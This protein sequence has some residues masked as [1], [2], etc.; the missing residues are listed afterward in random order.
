MDILKHNSIAWDNEVKNKNK[1]TIPVT[2]EEVE[3]AKNGEYTLLLTPTKAV[4]REWTSDLIGK[5]VLCL[6]SGG[7]Q[8]GPIFAALGANVTVFDN[9]KEQLLKDKM[10]SERDNLNIH[11]EK[12]DMRD[13][14]RFEDETFDFIFHP[15]SN[16]FI[17]DI[18]VVW[19][20][21]YRVLKKGGILISGF[22]NPLIYIFDLY[23]W[24]QNSKLVI[25]N[26]IPYSDIEQLPKDQ[27]K[28]R[29][30]TNDTLEFGHSLQS[31]IGDQIDAGFLISGFYEDNSG[32]DLLDK[33]IDTYIATKSIKL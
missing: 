26:H 7:G 27:L 25:K 13:L 21:C 30:D 5:N 4:P 33:Y 23:E 6:A 19:K 18:K 12:G 28:E 20:E 11:L 29:L 16:C 1:W 15:V 22:T 9:S 2:S 3:N 10:V 24:E 14:S 32:G 17:D 8:Q 31:Q